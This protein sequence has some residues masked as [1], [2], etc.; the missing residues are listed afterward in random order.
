VEIFAKEIERKKNKKM[1]RR[2][3]SSFIYRDESDRTKKNPSISCLSTN[4]LRVK[5]IIFGK[6]II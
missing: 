1:T 2:Q 5:N 6:R 4:V 3:N